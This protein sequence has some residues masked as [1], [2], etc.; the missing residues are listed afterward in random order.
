MSPDTKNLIISQFATGAHDIW[1]RNFD[2]HYCNFN[3]PSKPCFMKNPD[4][5]ESNINVHFTQ[6]PPLWQKEHLAIG[7]TTLYA[8]S[9]EYQASQKHTGKEFIEI[10]A[11]YIHSEWMKRNPKQEHTAALHVP[12]DT[13][14]EREKYPYRAQIAEMQVYERMFAVKSTRM[15]NVLADLGLSPSEPAG[16]S[17]L[18]AS[19]AAQTEKSPSP[20][21]FNFG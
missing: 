2:A 18:N 16:Q 8:I 17:I 4:G 19:Q 5:T 3:I 7:E 13:L 9:D 14:S 10:A 11:E 20:E 12:Y 1:R 15:M 6:L 21:G